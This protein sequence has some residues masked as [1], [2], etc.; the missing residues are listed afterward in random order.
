[1]FKQHKVVAVSGEEARDIFFGD[2]RLSLMEGYN[3]LTGNMCIV[4]S[5][6]HFQSSTVLMPLVT[7]PHLPQDIQPENE[8]VGA[9]FQKNLMSLVHKDRLSKGEVSQTGWHQPMTYSVSNIKR[10]LLCLATSTKESKAGETQVKLI[11]LWMFLM[12]VLSCPVSSPN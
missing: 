7:R 9:R 8:V 3:L 4:S 1:V 12:C 10:C 11:H 2:H 6:S 5:Q